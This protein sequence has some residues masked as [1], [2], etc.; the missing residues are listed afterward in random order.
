[1]QVTC[2]ICGAPGEVGRFCE[3]GCGR[4]P[5]AP[6]TA[7]PQLAMTFPE[8]FIEG[9]TERIV[10]AFSFP[11][12]VYERATVRILDGTEVLLETKTQRRPGLRGELAANLTPPRA[13]SFSFTVELCCRRDGEA[14]DEVLLAVFD[15][16]VKPRPSSINIQQGPITIDAKYGVDMAGVRI[17]TVNLPSVD[18]AAGRRITKP[19]MLDWVRGPHR[20]LLVAGDEV[21]QLLAQSHVTCGRHRSNDVALRV[22]DRYGVPQDE[23]SRRL[24]STHFRLKLA[25]GSCLLID[26]SE[27]RASTNGT[28]LNGEALV[29]RGCVR[30]QQG[31]WEIGFGA[32]VRHLKVTVR[33]FAN[34]CGRVNGCVLG[35]T[36]G[37]CRRTVL[38]ES[39]E[40]P[41]GAAGERLTWD[42]GLFAVVT[43]TGERRLLVPGG[44]RS[45]DGR[46]WRVEPFGPTWIH[47]PGRA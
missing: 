34:A 7:S 14:E 45:L 12:D 36:D 9:S 18:L 29:P 37:A 44:E 41:F 4:L 13:G 46:T 5:A 32:S 2:P 42:G 24:S 43:A 30:L 39:G 26:G 20:L 3:M 22:F 16:T 35:R 38:L 11:R 8:W 17:G 40:I 25:D 10:F 1:M 27:E 31:Q 28:Y 47:G 19:L 33:V 6:A 15:M 21:V 23:S